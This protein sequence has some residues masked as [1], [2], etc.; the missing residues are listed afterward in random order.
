MR[1]LVARIALIF[2][3]SMCSVLVIA[4]TVTAFVLSSSDSDRAAGPMARHIASTSDMLLG[5]PPPTENRNFRPRRP[6]PGEIVASLPDGEVQADATHALQAALAK[7]GEAR[8]VSVIDT[9]SG[10]PVAALALD[11]GRWMLFS[12]P[13]PPGPPP[14]LAFAAAAWLTLFVIGIV[15]VALTMAYR[16]TR[17]FVMLDEAVR[18]VGPDGVLP[19]TPE[20]GSG[21]ARRTAAALN[22]LS[23]RLRAAMESR[24]RLVAAAGHDFRTP[25]TR[26]RLRAE[27]L[28]PEDRDAWLAD[29]DELDAIADSAI[30]LVQEE[31]T[32]DDRKPL[33]LEQLVR[34]TVAELQVAK[35]PVTLG[36]LDSVSVLAGPLALRRALRNLITNAATHGGGARVRLEKLPED[37]RI[38]IEDDG[39]GIP[40]AMLSQVFEPFFRA[41]PARTQSIKGA[42]LG[43]AI[44]REII[45]R[46][47]GTIEIRNRPEGGLE[48][49]VRLRTVPAAA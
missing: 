36:R 10:E 38:V 23:D 18:S 9:G 35:L 31:G 22:A 49:A 47:G 15:I 24:M 20:V 8:R 26:M 30:K 46:F 27:F 3:L 32:G 6:P 5:A 48:Q 16:V 45:E 39:P 29:L 34:E 41:N 17:P 11:G 28:P 2:F 44:A 14:E 37:A 25:M 7:E 4:T 33:A 13:K 21:E 40:E 42:G 12:Y 19:H 43:L 1:G